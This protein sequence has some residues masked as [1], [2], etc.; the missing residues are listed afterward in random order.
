MNHTVEFLRYRKLSL[1]TMEKMQLLLKE[2]KCKHLS[3][4]LPLKKKKSYVLVY[5]HFRAEMWYKKSLTVEQKFYRKS[6]LSYKNKWVIDVLWIS[7]SRYFFFLLKHCSTLMME[8]LWRCLFQ[9]CIESV[10]WGR[11]M[12]NEWV[13]YLQHGAKGLV[14]GLFVFFYLLGF[15]EM[16][17]DGTLISSISPW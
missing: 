7:I 4:Q 13:L 16:W 3:S 1:R 11:G 5:F 10:S 6:T 17:A 14:W 15:S 9:S 12:E 2:H 8:C